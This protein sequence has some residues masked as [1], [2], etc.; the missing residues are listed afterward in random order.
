MIPSLAHFSQS[1]RLGDEME[2]FLKTKSVTKSKKYLTSKKQHSC[3]VQNIFYAVTQL[4]HC[5]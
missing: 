2:P 1:G 3:F 5:L 4:N